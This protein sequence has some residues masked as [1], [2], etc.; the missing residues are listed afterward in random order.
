MQKW[1]NLYDD[2]LEEF[3]GQGIC[4][5]MDSAYMGGIMGQIGREVWKMNFLGTCQSNRIGCGVTA[6]TAKKEL[7]VGSHESVMFQRNENKNL[8]YTMWAD[9]TIIKTLVTFIHPR[10]WGLEVVF[11]VVLEFMYDVN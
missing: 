10:S 2:M 3:K 11:S 9:N 5:T 8:T 4:V 7:K 6:K 1:V